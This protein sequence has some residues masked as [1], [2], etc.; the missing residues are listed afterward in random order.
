MTVTLTLI[1]TATDVGQDLFN[2]VNELVVASSSNY[3][4]VNAAANGSASIGNGFVQGIMSATTLAATDIRGGNVQT[5]NTLWLSSNVSL[6]AS[7]SFISGNIVVNTTTLSV[8]A[9]LTLNTSVLFLGNST[10]NV[11]ANSSK[12]VIGSSGVNSTAMAVG[13]NIIANS[14]SVKLDQVVLHPI[15]VTTTGTSAQEVDA[16]A[17]ATFRS[18]EYTLTVK[19]NV[20]NNYQISKMLLIHDGGAAYLTEYGILRSNSAMGTF[21]TGSNATHFTLTFTPVSANTTLKG[22]ATSS[23]V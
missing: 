16:I 17:I 12:L 13:S 14:T 4:T 6:N 10:V 11:L 19:D 5:A 3:V 18:S 20:A 22:V 15:T 2:R 8:G 1:D 9:N 21:A 7:F 23:L